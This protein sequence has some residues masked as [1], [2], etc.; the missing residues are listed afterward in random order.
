[1]FNLIPLEF[2]TLLYYQ[3]LLVVTFFTFVGLQRGAFKYSDIQLLLPLFLIFYMGLR[4]VSGRYFGD[5]A[6]Y[7]R[8]F[9]NYQ[10]GADVKNVKDI[11][12]QYL[13][14][15]ASKMMTVQTFFLVC[16]ALYIV[17]LY[18]VCRKWF[19]SYWFYAFLMVV[20][21]FSFW[22]YG[23]NGI[24]NGIAASLF[25]LAI[26][27]EKRVFQLLWLIA[28]VSFHKSMMLP[29]VGFLITMFY[30]KP[31]GFFYLWLAAIPLSLLLP[32][33]WDNMFASWIDDERISYLT[34]GNINNDNFRSVGFRW[35]FLLYSATGV[36]AG[37]Y[38]IF[39]KKLH[40]ALYTKLFNIFLFANAFWILVIR[41]NF[42]NRFAYL[43]WFMLAL[44]I[45]YPWLKKYFGIDQTKI[46]G[47]I[48]L[49]YFMFTYL[50]NMLV[51]G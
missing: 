8:M 33:F 48:T 4:P 39:K 7:S 9:I 49:V 1:M 41:T 28:S 18:L 24:R 30:N 16:A 40:D 47:W 43:S 6:T 45:V 21:S 22:A 17:P 31:E 3:I 51:Y 34:K 37:W 46:L 13:V 29:A 23:T 12:F 19:N 35:D 32:G 25:L 26:S 38:Y 42:S 27:R 36:Y 20:G 44:V 50:M 11:F 10:Q 2:Y 14:Y 15:Y 5:M